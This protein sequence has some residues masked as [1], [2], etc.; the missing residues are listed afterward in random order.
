MI[1]G[2]V[3]TRRLCWYNNNGDRIGSG[4]G[5]TKECPPTRVRVGEAG[6]VDT[7]CL[8]TSSRVTNGRCSFTNGQK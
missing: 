3:V 6:R 7:E 2:L 8:N 1:A 5:V 4:D